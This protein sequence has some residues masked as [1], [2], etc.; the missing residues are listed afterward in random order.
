MVLLTGSRSRLLN[1]HCKALHFH[2]NSRPNDSPSLLCWLQEAARGEGRVGAA[3]PR[4]RS[5]W[6]WGSRERLCCPMG[7]GGSQRGAGHM[8]AAWELVVLAATLLPPFLFGGSK[9]SILQKHGHGLVGLNANQST[10]MDS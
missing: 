7:P 5:G 3:C 10:S 6:E 4:S 2:C 8:Q 1:S 9:N